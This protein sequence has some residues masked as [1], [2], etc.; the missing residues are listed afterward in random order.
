MLSNYI[1]NVNTSI[2]K[3]PLVTF[4]TR[5]T[6]MKVAPQDRFMTPLNNR[7]YINNFIYLSIYITPYLAELS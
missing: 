1:I 4:E 7:R 2:Q 5:Y 3:V 6:E